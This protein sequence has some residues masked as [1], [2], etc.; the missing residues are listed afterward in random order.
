MKR[1]IRRIKTFKFYK[2]TTPITL[3]RLTNHIVHVCAYL[4]NFNPSLVP[5]PEVTSE[6]VVE[7]Y[8]DSTLSDC[9]D[10]AVHSDSSYV[11]D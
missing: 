7:R 6:S 3:A 8:F 2:K 4:S 1:A 9:N 11:Q 10:Y 5:P